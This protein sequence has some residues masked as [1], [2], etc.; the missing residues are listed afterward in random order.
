LLQLSNSK[1]GLFLNALLALH[2]GALGLVLDWWELQEEKGMLPAL[3]DNK[4]GRRCMC[5]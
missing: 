5:S 3:T 1:E 2:V 4:Y